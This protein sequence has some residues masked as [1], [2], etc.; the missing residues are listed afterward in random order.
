LPVET[1]PLTVSFLEDR[2]GQSSMFF[3]L[4]SAL[5]KT[6]QVPYAAMFRSFQEAIEHCASDEVYIATNTWNARIVGV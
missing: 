1:A 4:S 5:L 6:L 2:E 3:A